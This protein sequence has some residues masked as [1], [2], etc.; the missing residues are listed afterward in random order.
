MGFS[1]LGKAYWKESYTG[2]L[3]SLAF[4]RH[5]KKDW[6]RSRFSFN[7]FF[8]FY[9]TVSDIFWAF[10]SLSSSSSPFLVLK[11]ALKNAFLMIF[12]VVYLFDS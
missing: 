9:S 10:Q 5:C 4:G 6:A 8:L 7:S 2:F 1:N 12:L 3:S 11:D